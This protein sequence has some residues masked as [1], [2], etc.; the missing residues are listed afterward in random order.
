M[1]STTGEIL[2]SHTIPTSNLFFILPE[3]LFLLLSAR[4]LSIHPSG[5]SLGSTFLGTF[6]L[7][8]TRLD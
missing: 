2:R 4:I 6:I 5:L 7:S 8:D 3:I 1:D